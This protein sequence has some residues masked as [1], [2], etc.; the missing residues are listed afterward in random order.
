MSA[1]LSHECSGSGEPNKGFAFEV[2][3]KD[4][5]TGFAESSVSLRKNEQGEI[6]GFRSI[7]QDITERKRIEHQDE[8]RLKELTAFYSVSE[9]T[10]EGRYHPGQSV[11]GSDQYPTDKLAI[12]G[13]RLRQVECIGDSEFRTKNFT[14][15]AWKQ[16]API[17]VKGTVVGRIDV[18]Y[19]EQRPELDEG[20]FLK[21]ERLLIDA[22]AERIGHI[23][24]RKQAEEALRRARKN[25]GHLLRISMM[26]SMHWI[27]REI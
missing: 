9:L 14:D 5:T 22:I 4:G 18:G 3:R 25:T 27:P 2:T 19:L 26:S 8:E 13:D 10:I 6:I 23:T 24:E 21:E 16:S 17:K 1:R 15:S 7:S 11:S 20:P 12:P